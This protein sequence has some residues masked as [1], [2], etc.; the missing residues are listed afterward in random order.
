[1]RA[2]TE[3]SYFINRLLKNMFYRRMT[4]ASFKG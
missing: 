2:G 1:M 4:V 3:L